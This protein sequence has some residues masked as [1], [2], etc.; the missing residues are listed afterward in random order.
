MTRGERRVSEPAP[1]CLA[2]LGL[3]DPPEQIEGNQ[4]QNDDYEDRD[5]VHAVLP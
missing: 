4:N 3:E 1:V 5:D 2:P